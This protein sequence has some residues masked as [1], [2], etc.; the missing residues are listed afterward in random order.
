[1]ERSS[2]NLQ[3]GIQFHCQGDTALLLRTNFEKQKVKLACDIF[4]EKTVAALEKRNFTGTA[5]FVKMVPK[6]WNIINV[7]LPH[8]GFGT[9]DPDRYPFCSKSNERFE[10]INNVATTFKRMDNSPKGQRRRSPT[11]PASNALH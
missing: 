11:S 9:N 1:M 7:K 3:Y 10:Y 6:M 4:N 8:A 2:Y 5:I